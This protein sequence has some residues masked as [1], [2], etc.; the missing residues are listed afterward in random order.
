MKLFLAGLIAGASMMLA[1]TSA[2]AATSAT[3]DLTPDLAAYAGSSTTLV[4]GGTIDAPTFFGD[5]N[6]IVLSPFSPNANVGYFASGPALETQPTVSTLS[7]GGEERSMFSFLLGSPDNFNE[8]L[9]YNGASLITSLATILTNSGYGPEIYTSAGAIFIS[10]TD[11]LYTSVTFGATQQAIEFS[12]ISSVPVPAGV[13]L[14]GSALAGL[15]FLSRRN[16]SKSTP[17]SA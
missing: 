6:N 13:L 17:A 16:K 5:Q 2:Y 8:V 4:G 15:G 7:F 10:I 3:I 9:F 14:L 11:I 12:N 1:A